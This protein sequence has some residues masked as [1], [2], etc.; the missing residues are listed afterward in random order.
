MK[1]AENICNKIIAATGGILSLALFVSVI[2]VLGRMPLDEHERVVFLMN[3][4]LFWC[5]AAAGIV[6][7]LLL[8]RPLERIPAVWL[9]VAGAV[10]Y[11]I[12]AAY[13]ITHVPPVLKDD[14][15]MIRYHAEKFLHGDY[16]GLT[17]GYYLGFFPYQL[18]MLSYETALM[19]FSGSLRLLFA[20]NA[21]FVLLIDL[22][23]WRIAALMFSG[24]DADR[25][26]LAEKYTILLSYAFLPMLFFILF[27]YGF[28]PGYCLFLAAGYFLLRLSAQGTKRIRAFLDG[29]LVVLFLSAALIIKPNYIIGIIAV[30]LVAVLHAL[31]EKRA[32]LLLLVCACL[33]VPHAGREAM[34]VYYR[35]MTGI[36][37]RSGAPFLLNIAMG[38]QPEENCYDRL[39]GWYN[40]YNFMT[41]ED[42]GYSEEAASAAARE[43]TGRLAGYWSAHPAEAGEFFGIKILSTWCEPLFESVWIGPHVETGAAVDGPVMDS[44]Y[45][46][47]YVFLLSEKWM[48]IFL[49]ILYGGA[50]WYAAGSLRRGREVTG[51]QLLPLLFFLGGFFFHLISETNS[52][53]ALIYAYGLIPYVAYTAAGIS[54][55]SPARRF[56]GKKTADRQE[57]GRR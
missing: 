4:P 6:V 55:I 47:D 40:G 11:G 17:D 45:G 37:F 52:Q 36:P 33:I 22:L 19:R 23:Q 9:Y 31:R 39:G 51:V 1:K 14:P 48:Q 26:S 57:E 10:L 16:I 7:L 50:A 29:V 54:G 53:Y 34:Y 32:E 2:L 44:L 43:E 27:V 46:Q 15:Y 18:G 30:C 5:L 38:L 20:A 21:V 49:V 24:A 8:R 28:L 41:Y 56:R 35:Q 25:R 42:L 3:G 12:A 13:L